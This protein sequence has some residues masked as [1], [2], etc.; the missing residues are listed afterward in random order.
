[1]GRI[2]GISDNPLAMQTSVEMVERYSRGGAGA[3][4]MQTMLPLGL[5]IYQCSNASFDDSNGVLITLETTF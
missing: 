1:M 2:E 4:R 3:A 5:R